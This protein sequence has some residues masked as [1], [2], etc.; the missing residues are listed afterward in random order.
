MGFPGEESDPEKNIGGENQSVK[1]HCTASPP[2]LRTQGTLAHKHTDKRGDRK[3]T[4]GAHKKEEPRQKVEGRTTNPQLHL[5][6]ENPGEH[7]H[8]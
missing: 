2:Y 5:L 6:P 8:T 3:T 4:K 7:L 1:T